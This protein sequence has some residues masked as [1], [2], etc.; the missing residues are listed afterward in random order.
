MQNE[1]VAEVLYLCLFLTFAS[2]STLFLL[3]TILYCASFFMHYAIVAQPTLA[4]AGLTLPV[5]ELTLDTLDLILE[6]FSIGSR[7]LLLISNKAR[8]GTKIEI[9]LPSW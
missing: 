4:S 2:L 8:R 7:H 6:D 9:G 5:L 3:V 1:S